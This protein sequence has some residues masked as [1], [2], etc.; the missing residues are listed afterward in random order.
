MPGQPHLAFLPKESFAKYS[1]NCSLNGS[2]LVCLALKIPAKRGAN[3]L[4]TQLVKGIQLHWRSE[5]DS[6]FPYLFLD[7]WEISD[8][9]AATWQRVQRFKEQRHYL[10]GFE[11]YGLEF[12]L[13]MLRSLS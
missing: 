12:K 8:S 9:V 1:R 3:S 4:E 10:S 7:A 5:R 6:N 11:T 2:S 13:V